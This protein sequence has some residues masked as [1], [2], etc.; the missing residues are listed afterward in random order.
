MQWFGTCDGKACSLDRLL[1]LFRFRFVQQLTTSVITFCIQVFWLVRQVSHAAGVIFAHKICSHNVSSVRS[2]AILFVYRSLCSQLKSYDRGTD[3]MNKLSDKIQ[4]GAKAF[5]TTEYKYLSGFV[6]L[7]FAV[8][9]I[10]YS[11]DPPTGQYGDGSG[12]RIDGI[13][14]GSCFLAGA[15]LVSY[16]FC[17]ISYALPQDMCY[18]E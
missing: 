17:H 18:V 8:L 14:A 16:I 12:D 11:V 3:E 13:R 2:H 6:L 9:L 15:I 5:L 1:I 7:V 10:I 4:S